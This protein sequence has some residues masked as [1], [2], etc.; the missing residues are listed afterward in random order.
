MI[1]LGTAFVGRSEP[2]MPIG[3]AL[4][5]AVI[6]NNISLSDKWQIGNTHGIRERYVAAS[7]HAGDADLLVWP[8]SEIG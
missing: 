3:D 1:M 2:V 8:E 5:V 7:I 4:K 6:Q